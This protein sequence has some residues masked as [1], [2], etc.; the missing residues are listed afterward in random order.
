VTAYI[1]ATADEKLAAARELGV[2]RIW[3]EM[4]SPVIS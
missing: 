4:L 2:G 1:N 3:D